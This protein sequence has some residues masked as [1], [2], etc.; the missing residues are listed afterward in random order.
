MSFCPIPHTF[1]DQVWLSVG[2]GLGLGFAQILRRS[3][4][5]RLL[6]ATK[7]YYWPATGKAETIRMLLAEM[8]VAFEEVN[9]DKPDSVQQIYVKGGEG[10]KATRTSAAATAFFAACR[11]KGGNST[12]NTPMLEV[13]GRCYTQ[14]TAIY[15]LVARRGGLYPSDDAEASYIVDSV[16]AHCEDAFPLCYQALR[17]Q[18]SREELADTLVPKHLGNLE[19]LL[20]LHGGVW[21]TG[22]FSLADVRVADLCLH[23]RGRR[24]ER[25][26]RPLRSRPISPPSGLQGPMP[27]PR[28]AG[29]HWKASPAPAA[30]LRS[31][32]SAGCPSSKH[33]AGSRPRCPAASRPS[34]SS[35]RSWR[36]SR[37]GRG[38]PRTSRASATPARTSSA[39]CE[40]R[41]LQAPHLASVARPQPQAPPVTTRTSDARTPGPCDPLSIVVV[42]SYGSV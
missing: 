37:R 9:F 3:L 35:A 27:L 2:L 11:A 42:A 29:R 19:R 7:L 24:V 33:P 20:G 1:R 40:K 5:R 38:S 15:K 31:L 34:R 17:G 6:G 4:R 21:F 23:L 39:R 8:G 22:A 10:M 25:A 41:R 26:S 16:M 32:Q 12:T 18:V 30:G 13:D 28:K 14:S 36:E